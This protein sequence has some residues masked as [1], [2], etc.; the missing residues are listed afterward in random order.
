MGKAI[1]DG[2]FSGANGMAQNLVTLMGAEVQIFYKGTATR[3]LIDNTVTYSDDVSYT[4]DASP[5]LRY[6]SQHVNNT[7]IKDGDMYVIMGLYLSDKT[8]IE[9]PPVNAT[10]TTPDDIKFNIE[11]VD[12]IYSG[13]LVSAYKLQLR[14]K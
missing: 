7:T 3:N 10:V 5:P 1:F 11:S 2:I 9:K 8:L 14:R 12:I 13:Y 6:K 4:I